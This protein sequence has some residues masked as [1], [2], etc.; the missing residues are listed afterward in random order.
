M[1]R[2]IIGF[3]GAWVLLTVVGDLTLSTEG[4]AAAL[5]GAYALGANT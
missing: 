5:A 2:F 1:I 3:I 4:A